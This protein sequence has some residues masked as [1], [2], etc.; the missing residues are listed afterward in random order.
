MR[1]NV[2][3]AVRIVWIVAT[4]L[5]APASD[6]TASRWR[7]RIVR[8]TELSLRIEYGGYRYHPVSAGPP[9]ENHALYRTMPPRRKGQYES[10]F[11]RGNAMSAAPIINGT[12]KF[13]K[14]A[15][16]GTMTRNTIV[17]PC[18]VKSWL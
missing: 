6:E 18:I 4:K 16:I 1:R 10:A 11:R 3:P 13:P 5:I 17:S 9:G 2:I 7:P 14:P 15:K 8:S 12:R